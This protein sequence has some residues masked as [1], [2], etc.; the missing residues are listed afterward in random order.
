MIKKSFLLGAIASIITTAAF[1]NTVI[2]SQTYV[3]N[4]DAL[5]VNIA[6]GVGDNNANVGKT[7]IVN[8]SGN[9]ELGTV[10]VPTLPTGTEGNVVTYDSNG[11]IGGEVGVYYGDKEMR[12]A[13]D[14]ELVSVSALKNVDNNLKPT[15]VSYKTCTQWISGEPQTDA[16]CLLWNLSD[17]TVF[18]GCTT[19]TE[20]SWLNNCQDGDTASCYQNKCVCLGNR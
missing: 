20:C 9:L 15:T 3:D 19:S 13:D 8:S 1:A 5:K 7:L 4:A 18:G 14:A 11:D 17:K 10:D 16:N 12:Y 6:Q 2:T